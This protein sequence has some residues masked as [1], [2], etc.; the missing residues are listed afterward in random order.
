[1]E[2]INEPSPNYSKGR[3]QK[4]SK[5]V[6]HHTAGELAPSLA[7]LKNPASQV[8]AHYLMSRG[9]TVIYRL[10]AE[11][12]TAWHARQAN[13]FSIGIEHTST[14]Q[15]PFTGYKHSAKLVADICKR[16]K[17]NPKIAVKPH[18]DYVATACPAEVD[19]KRIRKEAYNLLKG[20][21]MYKG[22]TAKYWYKKFNTAQS[23]LV[24][25]KNY[26]KKLFK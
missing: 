5:V 13:P 19:W 25:I 21:D 17:L 14:A 24:K 11:K 6:I 2:I 10:V 7:H 15:K 1:M 23:K 22:K 26:I 8:S 20:S 18:S 16:H 9:G 4:I 12:N 3:T